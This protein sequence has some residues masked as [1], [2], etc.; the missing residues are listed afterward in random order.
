MCFWHL[1]VWSLSWH[2]GWLLFQERKILSF[3][4]L[5]DHDWLFSECQ[6]QV[7]IVYSVYIL[8]NSI[9]HLHLENKEISCMMKTIKIWTKSYFLLCDDNFWIHYLCPGLKM[10]VVFSLDTSFCWS[11]KQWRFNQRFRSSFKDCMSLV[12]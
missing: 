9:H 1:Y 10:H 8:T 6:K 2:R 3:G 5:C 11:R 4:G 12:M 7:Y